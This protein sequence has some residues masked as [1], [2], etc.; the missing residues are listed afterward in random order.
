MSCRASC[1]ELCCTAGSSTA[2]CPQESLEFCRRFLL[3][4]CLG[5]ETWILENPK[6]L[7]KQI[8]REGM[9]KEAAVW[10]ERSGFGALG[11][12][13]SLCTVGSKGLG[14]RQEIPGCFLCFRHVE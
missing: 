2:A 10:S 8:F 12:A 11:A 3:R 14:G 9:W 1:C 4:Q 13:W 6:P 5:K 7:G